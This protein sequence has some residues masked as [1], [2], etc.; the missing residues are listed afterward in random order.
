MRKKPKWYNGKKKKKKVYSTN[1]AGITG[2]QHVEDMQIDPY[3]PPFTKGKS[4]WNKDLNINP[5]TQN[6][7]E[8]KVGSNLAHTSTGDY[9]LNIIPV[10]QTLRATINKWDPLK[11][12][13]FCKA[14]NTVNKT[15]WQPVEWEKTADPGWWEFIHY[16]LTAGEPA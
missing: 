14:K 15:K 13:S 11:L 4:K 7:I 5:V 1:G 9:F 10:A 3:L 12:R 8:E 2:Y 6:L 16:G